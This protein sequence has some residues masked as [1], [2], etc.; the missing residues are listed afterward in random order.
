MFC[1]K[2]GTNVNN[3]TGLC[4]IC[5]T[6]VTS[7]A[8][9]QEQA[10]TQLQKEQVNFR[11]KYLPP[12]KP[13]YIPQPVYQPKTAALS[14]ATPMSVVEYILT[15]IVSL[16]PVIGFIMLLVWAFG[17]SINQNKKNFARAVLLILIIGVA[18][19][20]FFSIPSTMILSS[21]KK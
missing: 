4:S 13:Q 5:G 17:S 9:P 14:N 20:I 6:D 7:K 3:D 1:P 21:Q 10:Q 11:N 15:L 2:C 19:G 16:I 18:I 8:I 12:T